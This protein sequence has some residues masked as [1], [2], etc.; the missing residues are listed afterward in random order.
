MYSGQQLLAWADCLNAKLRRCVK[1]PTDGDESFATESL[2]NATRTDE[3]VHNALA[4]VEA[5][6]S[7]WAPAFRTVG[8]S[9]NWRRIAGTSRMSTH[10][11]GIAFDLN[12]DLGGYWRWSNRPEGDAGAYDNRIPQ[13][14]V[15]VFERRGFIWGGKW[16]HFDGMHFEYRPEIILYARLMGQSP[17]PR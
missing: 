14:V 3:A 15:Q 17:P 7:D 6:P 16:H 8:G 11:Y 13:D 10:S 9:F 12:A 4:E 2:N 1:L 5:L